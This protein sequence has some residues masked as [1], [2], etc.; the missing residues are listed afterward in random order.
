MENPLHFSNNIQQWCYPFFGYFFE[1]NIIFLKFPG[2]H[3]M[4]I[5]KQMS[6]HEHILR[7][8]SNKKP[9]IFRVN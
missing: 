3:I 2:I 1:I 9:R 4:A 8:A 5:V 7:H 6:F